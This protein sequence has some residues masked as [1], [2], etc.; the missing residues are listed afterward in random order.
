M[1]AMER[2]H[3]TAVCVYFMCVLLPAIFSINPVTAGLCFFSGAATLYLLDREKWGRTAVF[4]CGAVLV[5]G[6][7]NPL[8]N[9]NGKTVLFFLNRNPVTLEATLY[10]LIMGFMIGSALIWGRCFTRVMDTDRLMTVMSGLNPKVSLVCS[11]ALRYIPLLRLQAGSIREAQEGL[12]LLREDNGPDRIRSAVRRFDGLTTWGLE[13]GV[14][15][16]DSMT[17]RGYGS[18]RRTRYRLHP[19]ESKDTL[20]TA[21]SL[22]LAAA[23]AG[24]LIS[25]AIRYEWMPEMK[26]PE[27]GQLSGCLYGLYTILCLAGAAEEITDRIRWNSL[28][29]RI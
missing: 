28:R 7:L 1:K 19:W 29:S 24:G 11:M 8:F 17:A 25:G 12:G 26:R 13:N 10:G 15:M 14:V 21:C 16:A 3:P 2:Q 6:L 18:G 22:I 23:V 4:S 27:A 9:H 20:W 5:S